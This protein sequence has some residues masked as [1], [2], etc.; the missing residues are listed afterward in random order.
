MQRS[1][2]FRMARHGSL[3]GGVVFLAGGV[4]DAAVVGW[5]AGGVGEFC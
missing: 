4:V 3:L 2:L 1:L 5:V